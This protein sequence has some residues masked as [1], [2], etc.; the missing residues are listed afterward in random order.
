V[1]LLAVAGALVQLR[2]D[3]NTDVAH[4]LPASLLP[5]RADFMMV[6]QPAA[7]LVAGHGAYPWFGDHFVLGYAPPFIVLFALF[8]FLSRDLAIFLSVALTVILAGGT[9]IAWAGS[10]HRVEPWVLA[11]L[12]S[13]PLVSAVRVDQLMSAMGLAALSLAIWASRRDLWW[14]AGAAAALGLA[15]TSNA[16]PVVAMLLVSGWGRPRRLLEA[17]AGG[18]LLLAPLAAV[19]FAWDANWIHDYAHN[20]SFYPIVGFARVARQM[21]GGAGDVGFVLAACGIAAAFV[22]RCRRRPL[23]LDRAAFGLATTAIFASQGGLFTG[24]FVLPAVARLA[25][26]PGFSGV[27]WLVSVAPWLVLLVLAPRI[28]GTHPEDANLLTLMVPMMVIVCYPLVRSLGSS[29]A[30]ASR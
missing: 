29:S 3:S 21:G 11:L 27:A 20:L 15:R 2:V 23:D 13:A 30:L 19:S 1:L 5:E 18:A 12:V 26:R 10:A 28:L 6:W 7:A 17:A 9:V 14:L 8:G 4:G 24:V 25:R 16:L 22:W